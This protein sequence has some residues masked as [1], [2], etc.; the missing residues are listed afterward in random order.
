MKKIIYNK[1]F[2][3]NLVK[4]IIEKD[5]ATKSMIVDALNEKDDKKKKGSALPLKRCI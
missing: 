2:L 1:D 4:R 3:P 5:H